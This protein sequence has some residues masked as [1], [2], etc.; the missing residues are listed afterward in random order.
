MDEDRVIV[1][2]QS[3]VGVFDV[4]TGQRIGRIHDGDYNWYQSDPPFIRYPSAEG[5]R[6]VRAPGLWG[7][8]LDRSTADGWTCQRV[9]GGAVLRSEGHPDFKVE[10]SEEYRA[11]GV[12][13]GGGAFLYAISPGRPSRVTPAISGALRAMSGLSLSPRIRHS[14]LRMSRCRTGRPASTAAAA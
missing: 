6:L 10:Y 8:H 3:G 7:G 14:V 2:Y 1:G 4:C 9:D 13:A 5:I 11:M 12:S